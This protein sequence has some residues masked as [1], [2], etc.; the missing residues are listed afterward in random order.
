[1]LARKG[2]PAGTAFRV[3]REALAAEGEQDDVGLAGAD[4]SDLAWLDD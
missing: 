3:V 1:V 2:Y 4:S